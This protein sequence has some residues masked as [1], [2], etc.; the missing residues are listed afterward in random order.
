[1][2]SLAL[3][4]SSQVEDAPL[5]TQLTWAPG[6]IRRVSFGAGRHSVSHF[7]TRSRSHPQQD[8]GAPQTSLSG[9]SCRSAVTPARPLTLNRFPPNWADQKSKRG[10]AR[11]PHR[12]TPRS[13]V[14]R[15]VSATGCRAAVLPG[16]AGGVRAGRSSS[17]GRGRPP[18]GGGRG[19]NGGKGR[20]DAVSPRAGPRP[21]ALTPPRRR[22]AAGGGPNTRFPA[23]AQSSPHRPS[24]PGCSPASPG[25]GDRAGGPGKP[26]EEE[27]AAHGEDLGLR[28][29]HRHGAVSVHH[30][31]SQCSDLG[32]SECHGRP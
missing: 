17:G 1:M 24:A 5:K 14:A 22:D 8:E 19:P 27:G 11:S 13:E 16:D 32:T 23:S 28:H 9:V 10:L 7:A 30:G 20:P 12:R 3:C 26:P 15:F 29:R 25:G 21:A 6:A 2:S 18:R 4:D 31:P